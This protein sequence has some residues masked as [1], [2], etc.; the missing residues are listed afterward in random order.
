MEQFQVRC[1][2]YYAVDKMT[3]KMISKQI[4]QFVGENKHLLYALLS[5]LERSSNRPGRFTGSPAW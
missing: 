2:N 4:Q 3:A 1:L 5:D